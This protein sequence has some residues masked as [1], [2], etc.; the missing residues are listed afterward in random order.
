[1]TIDIDGQK[2]I[3]NLEKAL[4]E[5]HESKLTDDKVQTIYTKGFCKGMIYVM[6]NLGMINEEDLK[7]LVAD[8]EFEVPSIYRTK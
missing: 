6:K 8:T 5:Y 2:S 7:R 4:K 1:M 3:E